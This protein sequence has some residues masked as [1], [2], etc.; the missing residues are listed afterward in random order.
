MPKRLRIAISNAQK[1]AL[2]TWYSTYSTPGPKTTLA[3]ASTW[4]HSCY[5]YS[6]SSSTASDILSDKN[7]HLDS[8]HIKLNA[9]NPRTAKWTILEKALSDWALR[10]DQS[11]STVTG[12]L[13][14]LKA[15]LAKII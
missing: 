15:I 7:S 9:K 8:D 11:H 10:F 13:L 1:M 2:R 5:G 14:R 12:D 4:W 3:D 6:L